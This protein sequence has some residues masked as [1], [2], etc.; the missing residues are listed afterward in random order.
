MTVGDWIERYLGNWVKE[1]VKLI[2]ER[3]QEG[4]SF[5]IKG[6]EYK[7]DVELGIG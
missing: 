1:P 5:N 2:V 4:S 6:V 3:H 7:Y